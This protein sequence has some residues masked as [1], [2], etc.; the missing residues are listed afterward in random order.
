MTT[1]A[2]RQLFRRSKA[3]CWNCRSKKKKCDE[4][5][6]HCTRCVRAGEGCRYPDGSS[7]S[8]HEHNGPISSNDYTSPSMASSSSYPNSLSMHAS[9]MLS[10]SSST[11]GYPSQHLARRAQH[12]SYHHH[13]YVPSS[14]HHAPHSHRDY[15]AQRPLSHQSPTLPAAPGPLPPYYASSHPAQQPQLPQQQFPPP[16]LSASAAAE[17]DRASEQHLFKRTRY[18]DHDEKR[19][20]C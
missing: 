20:K 18:D 10:R 9:P 6:P 8:L 13:P 1:S 14:D 17:W 5:R 11:S 16:P 15:H 12:S 3:G 19:R 2:R 7:E 4:L